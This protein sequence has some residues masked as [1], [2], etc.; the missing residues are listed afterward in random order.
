MK[1]KPQ[2]FSLAVD[3]LVLK[4]SGETVLTKHSASAG[5]DC[6]VVSSSQ[7]K[8]LLSLKPQFQR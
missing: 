1:C 8:Y 2:A 4:E 7:L 3:I 6:I 5:G